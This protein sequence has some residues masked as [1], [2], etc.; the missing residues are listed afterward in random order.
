SPKATRPAPN[1]WNGL[2]GCGEMTNGLAGTVPPVMPPISCTPWIVPD[3]TTVKV[4]TWPGRVGP[5]CTDVAV[6]L[7]PTT[8]SMPVNGTALRVFGKSNRPAPGPTP[9]VNW[10][11]VIVLS[12]IRFSESPGRVVGALPLTTI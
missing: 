6:T 9:G 1:G 10:I 3:E 7:R 8:V 5:V 12:R 4:P 11:A 2:T